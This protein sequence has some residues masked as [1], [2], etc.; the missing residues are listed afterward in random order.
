M[1]EDDIVSAGEH[2]DTE[3]YTRL[4]LLKKGG[5]LAAAG[6]V[7]APLMSAAGQAF[8]ATAAEAATDPIA[9]TAVQAAKKYS[10][11]KLTTIRETGPQAADDK[12]F[13]GPRWKA[14]TG[15]EV[16]TIEGAMNDVYTKQVAEHVA[17]S[18]KIDVVEALGGWLPDFA[19]R[20]VIVPI[21]DYLA[22][23]KA[24]ATIKDIHPA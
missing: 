10:G 6:V 19:D 9:T 18:G 21:D 7:A 16:E 1:R 17:K 11:V 20:G 2:G 24:Q 5:R 15:I 4:S 14:L 8:A 22:R 23:Y 13:G 3:A 12:L